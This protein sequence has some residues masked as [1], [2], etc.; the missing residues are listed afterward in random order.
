M[1]LH[2]LGAHQGLPQPH[3]LVLLCVVRPLA[4]APSPSGDFA[5]DPDDLNKVYRAAASVEF[6]KDKLEP[7]IPNITACHD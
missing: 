4:G 3:A 7:R 1:T 5:W 2:D 6:P